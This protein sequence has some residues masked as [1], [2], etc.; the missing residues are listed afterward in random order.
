MSRTRQLID[1]L[2]LQQH[3]EGGWYREVFRSSLQVQPADGRPARQALTS[4]YFL[5]EAGRHSRWH[6]VLSDEVWVHLE[7]A[8]VELL[9]WQAVQGS[10]AI[11]TVLGPVDGQRQPQQVVAAGL[12]QAARPLDDGAGFS[13][14]A[15][16]VGP[17]FDFTDFSLMDAGGA[18][19][20]LL[21]SDHPSLATFI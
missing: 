13:L 18:E 10:A 19:A 6:K 17:G 7:G 15:C 16:M 1:Q 3:P 12:W 14:V 9:T 21:R 4:I 20:T 2:Q 5:L 8:P 11:T